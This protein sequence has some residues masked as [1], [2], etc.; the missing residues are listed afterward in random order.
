MPCAPGK[1]PVVSVASEVAVVEGK[2]VCTL[3]LRV[4]VESVGMYSA[5]LSITSSPK[6]SIKKSTSRP[7]G[8]SPAPISSRASSTPSPATIAGKI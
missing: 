2:A 1:V 8:D 3:P 4:K 6:P 5:Y 7:L